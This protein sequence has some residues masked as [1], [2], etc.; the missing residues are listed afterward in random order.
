M[1]GAGMRNRTEMDIRELTWDEPRNAR[2]CIARRSVSLIMVVAL[3]ALSP[4]LAGC[5]HDDS[6]DE[7]TP[8][9][10]DGGNGDGGGY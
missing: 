3:F 1:K 7:P 6:G 2:R 9:D 5:Y 4:A 10:T 8:T